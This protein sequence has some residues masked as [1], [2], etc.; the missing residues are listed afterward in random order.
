MET[1][2]LERM[3]DDKGKTDPYTK[4]PRCG[5][6]NPLIWAEEGRWVIRGKVYIIYKTVCSKCGLYFKDAF[7]H[8]KVDE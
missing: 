6:L 2:K 1:T 5:T 4:C 7:V 8:H 3:V